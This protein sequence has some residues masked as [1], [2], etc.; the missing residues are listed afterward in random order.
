MKLLFIIF[1]TLFHEITIPQKNSKP[2]NLS[3]QL[4]DNP[5]RTEEKKKSNTPIAELQKGQR[6][7]PKPIYG[8]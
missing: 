1:T 6:T 4:L 7:T 3:L 2:S 8:N 5:K